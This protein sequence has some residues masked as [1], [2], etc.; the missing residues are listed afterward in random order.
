M[1]IRGRGA[2]DV[3][4]LYSWLEL[5]CSLLVT[6]PVLRLSKSRAAASETRA[7]RA[8]AF[9]FVRTRPPYLRIK[10]RLMFTCCCQA[11]TLN[12]TLCL[13]K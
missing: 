9:R 5:T 7:A 2:V 8:S 12:T 6:V 3:S 13:W 1:L 11:L 10:I 4:V